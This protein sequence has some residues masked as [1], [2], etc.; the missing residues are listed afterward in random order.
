MRF[1]LLL[2]VLLTSTLLLV[3]PA[4]ATTVNFDGLATPNAWLGR[5]NAWG[6]VPS[7][8]AGFNWNGWEVMNRDSYNAIYGL[9]EVTLPSNPNF[10]YSGHDTLT[11][12]MSS[13]T[14]FYF[15]GTELSRWSGNLGAPGAANSVTITGW[16]GATNVGSVT[17]V[18]LSG[19]ANS[20]GIVGAVDRLEFAPAGVNA[21]YFRVD[22]L[23]YDA[24]P[25]PA[26]LGL[27]GGG[28]I[29]LG[30]WG[31]RQRRKT[32]A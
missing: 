7:S 15:L 4:M 30:F 6:D 1:R 17:N 32:S 29:G 21:G 13:G 2:V 8:Y 14:P 23:S 19:W 9:S 20:G 11:L 25:E 22:N 10:A 27:L 24:V 5:A 16:L 18:L 26:T 12:T 28:L 31:R 3:T